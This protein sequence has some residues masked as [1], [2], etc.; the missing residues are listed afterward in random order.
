MSQT[1]YEKIESKGDIQ[2][3]DILAKAQ[4]KSKD[5]YDT[6]ISKANSDANK[7][8]TKAKEDANKT[9]NYKRRL[10]DLEKRQALL[11]SK[12]EILD[13]IFDDVLHQIEKFEG[14]DLLNY[15]IKL[16]K[17]EKFLGTEVIKVNKRDYNKYLKALS[18]EKASN[19]VELDILNKELKTSFKLS[20]VSI[21]IKNGFLLEGKDFDLNFSFDEI[22]NNLRK[23]NELKIAQELFE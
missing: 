5:I 16:L 17:T 11:T 4:K 12:Q 7:L 20:N 22:I 15:V 19:L 1:I 13:S 23:E 3:R 10:F 6:A 2:V 18:S 9:L 8:I 21:N 14:K